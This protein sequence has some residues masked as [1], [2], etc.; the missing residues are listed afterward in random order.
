M[1]QISNPPT[2]FNLQR[3]VPVLENVIHTHTQ[4]K[5]LYTE[6][7]CTVNLFNRQPTEAITYGLRLLTTN[8]QRE[9]EHS[10]I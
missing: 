6:Y 10:T 3:Q 7:R 8:R 2:S 1:D 4:K 9:I 5:N